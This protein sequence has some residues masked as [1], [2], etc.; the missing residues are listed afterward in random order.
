MALSFPCTDILTAVKFADQSFRSM[1][2]QEL[3]GRGNV[4]R[5]KDFGSA[6]WVADYETVPLANDD[7]VSYEAMLTSLDGVIRPFE[8]SDLRRIWPRNYPLGTGAN[9]GT[10]TS[11]TNSKTV[12]LSGL[13]AAQVVSR[14]DFLSFDY[15]TSRA[16][17]QVMETVTASGGVTPG[18]EVRPYV[19]AGYTISGVVT[20]KTPRGRF[21]LLP[22]SVDSKLH[23]K[24]HSV[25]SFR[26]VQYIE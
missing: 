10:L 26:A 7:A 15:G 16:L 22:E 17:H 12:V 20:L 18:F 21:T 2:I 3:S 4:V 13:V 8:A 5:G 14:G 25:I 24:M 19:R 11:V 1:S 9:D 23:G 6:V